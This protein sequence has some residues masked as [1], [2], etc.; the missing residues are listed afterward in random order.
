[1]HFRESQEETDKTAA[2]VQ[3]VSKEKSVMREALDRREV[4]VCPGRVDCLAVLVHPEPEEP[5][6]QVDKTDRKDHQVSS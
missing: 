5:P 1:M 6:D 3:P 4:V 2:M